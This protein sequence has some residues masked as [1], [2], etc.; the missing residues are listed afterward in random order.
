VNLLLRLAVLGVSQGVG[1]GGGGMPIGTV[2]VQ[3]PSWSTTAWADNSW[4]DI[5]GGGSLLLFMHYYAQQRRQ[6]GA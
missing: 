2:W 4:A 6:S 5:A 1:G 3:T